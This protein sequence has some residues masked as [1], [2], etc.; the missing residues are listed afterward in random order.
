MMDEIAT[1]GSYPK[2]MEFSLYP[3]VLCTEDW[4]QYDFFTRG[5][6]CFGVCDHHISLVMYMR[7]KRWQWA[8]H[9]VR[10][11]DYRIP[12]WILERSL[13]RR[14]PAGKPMNRWEDGSRWIDGKM[15]VQKNDAKLLS[16]KNRRAAASIGVMGGRN[17][18]SH[19]QETGQRAIGRRRMRSL[20]CPRM[21]IPFHLGTSWSIFTKFCKNVLYYTKQMYRNGHS[22][23]YCNKSPSS[24]PSK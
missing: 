24:S 18:G 16:M 21:W 11:F 4:F 2:S 3:H 13:G 7:V 6:K 12:K 14:R 19:G 1:A 23:F 15:E 9:V 17:R 10:T 22:V 20:C 8:G 5:K